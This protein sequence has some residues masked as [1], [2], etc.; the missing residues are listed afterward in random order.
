MSTAKR[1]NLVS[2]DDYLSGELISPR[3]HEYLGGVLYATAGASNNHNV[4]KLNTMAALHTSLRGRPCRPFNSDTKI[5]I[6]FNGQIRFYY[7]DGSVT[8]RPNPPG[9]SFQDEPAAI[10]EVLSRGTRRI[11][12]GEKKDVYLTIPSLHIYLLIEQQAPTVVAYRRT[13]NEFEREVYQGL[14]A[15][16]PLPEIGIDLPLA[17]I[18]ETVQ[19]VPEAEDDDE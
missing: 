3:R 6:R 10:L 13:K 4:I 19:F 15:V 2:V 16:I 17:D 18:Y 11:D 9:D 1:W 12:E 5:R 14:D 8:C 7:P